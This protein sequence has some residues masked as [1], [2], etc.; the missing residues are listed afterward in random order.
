VSAGRVSG[1]LRYPV[2]SMAG[3]ELAEVALD[4]RGLVGD[5]GWAVRTDD[6]GI[7][8]GKTTRRFRR[9][10]GLLE[11]RAVL[12]GGVP[13]VESPTGERCSV[14]DAAVR[15][16]AATGRTLTIEAE[17]DVPHHDESPVHLLTTASLRAL[18]ELLRRPVEVARFRP[19]VVLDV[20]G[21]GFPEDD[22]TGRELALG[23]EVVL[24]LGPGMPRCAMVG[25]PQGRLGKDKTILRTLAQERDLML[26]LQASVVHGGTVR[27]GDAAHLR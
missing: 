5:R 15:L 23:D 4:A 20:A 2:K 6:G 18:G 11:W 26:G 8:S 12:E 7:G 19:N 9:V 24:R 17:A 27:R 1:L 13:V 3:E 10:D 16:G 22:W 14:E 25:F 21:P